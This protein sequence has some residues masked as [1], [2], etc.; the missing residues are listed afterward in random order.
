MSLIEWFGEKRK[1]SMMSIIDA[2]MPAKKIVVYDVA[3]SASG[4]LSVLNDFYAEVRNYNDKSIKWIFVIS[5][6]QLEETEN[7][8]VIRK[9]WVK[10]NWLCRLF[11]D[12]FVAPRIVKRERPYKIFSLQ[13]TLVLNSNVGQVLYLHQP[14]PFVEYKF[15]LLESPLF[16]IYQNIIARFIYFS[17]KRADKVI[18]QTHWMKDACIEGTG[19]DSEKIVVIPPVVNIVP[20]KFFAYENMDIPT[21]IY[22]A[23]PLIYKNH[24]VIIEACKQLVRE[25]VTNFRVI[26]TMT[27]T[28]NKLAHRLK[29]EAEKYNLPIQFVGVLKRDE[30]FEWYSK[31]ILLFPSYIETFGLPLLEAKTYGAPVIALDTS[32][33]REILN[34]YKLGVFFQ[35]K[36]K[37]CLK[38]IILAEMDSDR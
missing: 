23:T 13:N 6:P 36:S 31:A 21:F 18:V 9:P 15:T 5:T 34:Q 24:K 27:G 20:K 14:L 28:E 12:Y 8:K 38:N 32:F 30:L 2:L 35:P 16:W 19:V 33:A 1:V 26:F 25:R 10:K 22:P 7:I 17:V 11:F 4:A 29:V 37:D 3:A